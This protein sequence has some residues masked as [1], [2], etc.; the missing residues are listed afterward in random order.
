VIAV[1]ELRIAV[2]TESAALAAM[3]RTPREPGHLRNPR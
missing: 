2:E 1:L 3:R